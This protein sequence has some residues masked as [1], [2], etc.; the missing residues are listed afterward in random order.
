MKGRDPILAY[1]NMDYRSLYKKRRVP[2]ATP[3]DTPLSLP[4]PLQAPHCLREADLD[5]A[6]K[7]ALSSPLEDVRMNA[8]LTA[9]HVETLKKLDGLVHQGKDLYEE[10]KSVSPGEIRSGGKIGGVSRHS[11][12][13]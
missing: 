4:R 6:L 10:I 1:P 11:C 7:R 3:P 2:H 13:G 9:D 5:C 8:S 12:W